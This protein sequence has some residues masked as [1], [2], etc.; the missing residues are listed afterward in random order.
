MEVGIFRVPHLRG[1]VGFIS[2]PEGWHFD[3]LQKDAV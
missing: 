2:E 3:K 1:A